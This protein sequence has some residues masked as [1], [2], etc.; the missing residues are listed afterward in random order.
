MERLLILKQKKFWKATIVN[1]IYILLF[2]LATWSFLQFIGK[3]TQKLQQTE[4]F[5]LSITEPA[6][7]MQHSD[8]ILSAA[9]VAN[10]IYTEWAIITTAY[11]LVTALLF[12]TFHGKTSSILLNN[13][14]L[15]KKE[16]FEFIKF[17]LKLFAIILI[18]LL[19][20][21]FLSKTNATPYIFIIIAPT[22][23]LLALNVSAQ[24][25]KNKTP[26]L[27]TLVEAIT[28][29]PKTIT[30]FLAS[31]ITLIILI[32]LTGYLFSKIGINTTNV[33]LIAITDF[34]L[35]TI[36]TTW[37]TNATLEAA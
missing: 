9:P 7:V 8:A 31:I 28:K 4:L 5:K 21:I 25:L 14:S 6:Q 24:T 34:A 37:M 22:L 16:F 13:M 12:A 27:K 15:T 30:L 20:T 18:V 23:Y 19:G 2:L 10:R 17:S 29:I 36:W 3:S 11:Y 1:A 32:G 35:F 33:I 26:F